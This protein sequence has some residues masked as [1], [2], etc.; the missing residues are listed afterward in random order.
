MQKRNE[1]CSCGSGKKFKKCCLP[2]IKDA[3]RQDFEERNK[4]G[5]EALRQW[6]K[7][8]FRSINGGGVIAI[9]KEN[10]SNKI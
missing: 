1:I 5:Q 3:E 7:S 10:Q 6:C 4:D 9:K 8:F 2:R